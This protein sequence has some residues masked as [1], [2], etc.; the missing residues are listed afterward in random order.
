MSVHS[1]D[2][3]NC[4]KTLL[5]IS[6]NDPDIA[7]LTVLLEDFNVDIE[8]TDKV[9]RAISNSTQLQKV[10]VNG[11]HLSHQNSNLIHL[12]F[13]H[14]A[15]NRSIVHLEVVAFSHSLVDIFAT[16]APFFEN[17]HNLHC[18]DI[19]GCPFSGAMPSFISVL[20][21]SGANRLEK[22][23]LYSNSIRDDGLVELIDALNVMPGLNSLTTLNLG[24]NEIRNK[25]W[26][27]LGKLLRNPS[28][29]IQRLDLHGSIIM[30]DDGFSSIVEALYVNKTLKSL[31]LSWGL[32]SITSEGWRSLSR[33]LKS[34]TCLLEALYLGGYGTSIDDVGAIFL[35]DA[36]AVNDTLKCL[37]FES[38]ESITSFGWHQIAKCLSPG[39]ALEEI[40]VSSCSIDDN[41]ALLL[42]EVLVANTALKKLHMADNDAITEQGW[43]E[44]LQILR[45]SS[46]PLEELI[47]SSNNINVAGANLVVDMVANIK[48]TVLS[49]V[50]SEI[51]I[52]ANQLSIFDQV[53]HPSSTS[54]LEC[55]FIGA[56]HSEEEQ[57]ICHD[58]VVGGF[59]AALAN[60]TT[61]T[62]LEVSGINIS[63][64]GYSALVNILCNT[65]NGIASIYNSNHT[66]HHM[67]S[68]WKRPREL[69]SM[70]E[71][72]SNANK[73]EV[74]HQKIVTFYL[75]DTET[76][77][78]VF[79]SM[80]VTILPTAIAS[81][82]RDRNGYS[83][84]FHLL[85]SMPS[86]IG[87]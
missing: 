76:A 44:C 23:S 75:S 19:R 73:G 54:K 45:D 28:S 52:T 3:L 81:I 87:S 70:L 55:L 83:A 13:A 43:N 47:F 40:H 69:D 33:F 62:R 59:A 1:L 77:G 20:C 26:R 36:F 46:A 64:T 37:D 51:A 50:M 30:T 48:S 2:S 7:G 79:G 14:L 74:V 5:R 71:L 60:N 6:R 61:L 85:R 31:D 35:G 27:K 21:Q 25:G 65:T 32:R 63:N 67:Y 58:N 4:D 57:N 53:M 56:A 11:Y 17:N 10:A 38:N 49:L 9:G 39:T 18:I 72:N 15:Q 42:F 78:R 66:L 80:S 12:F 29:K 16:L 68:G 8:W 34:K 41:G 24:G 22:I 86:M 82:G 84:I